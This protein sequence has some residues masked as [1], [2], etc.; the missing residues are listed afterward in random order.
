MQK[1]NFKQA[2][3]DVEALI[4]AHVEEIRNN[5]WGAIKSVVEQGVS[6]CQETWLWLSLVNRMNSRPLELLAL[7]VLNK[8]SGLAD[9]G[10]NPAG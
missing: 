9:A 5:K 7:L 3:G 8:V 4:E 10:G 2:I 1:R 6:G